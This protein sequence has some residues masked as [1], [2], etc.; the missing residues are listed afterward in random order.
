[1]AQI[2]GLPTDWDAADG[3]V[4]D[5]SLV[6]TSPAGPD[7]PARAAKVAD[8]ETWAYEVMRFRD[9][10][11]NRVL[12]DQKLHDE[13]WNRCRL[14]GPAYFITV[15]CSIFEPRT[16]VTP[17]GGGWMPAIPFSFQ[18][19]VLD[20]IDR[21]DGGRGAAANGA[22]SKSR[23][24]GATWYLCLW[25]LH[26]FLFKNPFSAKFIS[27]REDLV[28]VPGNLDSMM[29]RIAA[30]LV[31]HSPVR[32]PDFLVPRGW[33]DIKCRKILM[34]RNPETGNILTG[35]ST[36]AKSGRGGRSLWAW[37]DEASFIDRVRQLLAALQQTAA[38]VVPLSSESVETTEDFIDYRKELAV[39]NPDSVMELD[40][41]LH[42][43]HDEPWL[44]E[45][46]ERYA[47]DEEGFAR[48]ILRQPYA[49][50][51]GWYYPPAQEMT[52]WHERI[53][54]LPGLPLYVGIDPGDADDCALH[55]IMTN[56]A[57]GWDA[58]LESYERSGP[59]PEHFG[60]IILGCDPDAVAAAF[61]AL[62]FT[63][64]DRELMEWTRTLPQPTLCG[65]PA[66]TQKHHG[67][68]WY[69]KLVRFSIDHNPR[70][71]PSTG[72]GQPLVILKNWQNDAR[73]FQGRR[74]ATLNWL[75]RLRFND[76][77]EVRRSLYAIQRSRYEPD[78]RPRQAEQKKPLHDS[79]S[80]RRSALEYVA[81]NLD[82]ARLARGRSMSYDAA[83]GSRDRAKQRSA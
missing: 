69:D 2:V 68:T 6:P 45:Q 5:L 3:T 19:D 63:P 15:W 38:H 28:D 11:Q 64:M 55:W 40:Y 60:A 14:F 52:V 66:G 17:M 67:D 59:P 53:D 18:V 61:P 72:K 4:L 16:H 1:M 37:V 20:W 35:E 32:L 81:V 21:R 34:I 65:D 27:R 13:E 70:K 12:A 78:D 41:W 44:A 75:P 39:I 77:P 49:G 9:A 83:R 47:N 36:S 48:E 46:K 22:I 79:L 57:D 82:V 10:H 58:M 50:F 25:N 7:D 29:E 51:G 73:H 8:W 31:S 26:G 74:V 23:D 54:Y 80:H 71:N 76:T 33:E 30:H 24:M 43:Y 42:P 56:G 62:R